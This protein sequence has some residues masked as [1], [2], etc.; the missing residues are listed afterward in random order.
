MNTTITRSIAALAASGAIVAGGAAA[1]NA[2]DDGGQRSGDTTPQRSEV[3]QLVHQA[4]KDGVVTIQEEDAIK[5][6]IEDHTN[7]TFESLNHA[8]PQS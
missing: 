7:V 3:S 5:Q 4:V 6:A 8:V 1:A 2:H